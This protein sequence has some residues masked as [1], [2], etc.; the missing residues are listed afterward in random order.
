MLPWIAR[1]IMA[2]LIAIAAAREGK[3]FIAK[4]HS[5]SP[6]GESQ[7]MVQAMRR[8]NRVPTG[9]MQR[10]SGEFRIAASWFGW[11]NRTDPHRGGSGGRSG[12][13]L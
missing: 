2:R 12:R 5:A 8:H 1:W 13:S 7:Q 3:A 11:R 6:F 4:N 9:S 10:S